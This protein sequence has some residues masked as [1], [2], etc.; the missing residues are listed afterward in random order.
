M[1]RG[2]G[3]VER[4]SAGLANVRAGPP[5]STADHFRIGSVTKT[6]IAT[7][8]LRLVAQGKLRLS[9]CGSETAARA[10]SHG[11]PDHPPGAVQSLEWHR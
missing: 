8:V 9:D 2:P 1:I 5:I 4:Y 11:E 10:G 7:V 3:E 6:F